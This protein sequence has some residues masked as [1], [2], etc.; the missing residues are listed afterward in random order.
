MQTMTMLDALTECLKTI[1]A[2]G[3]AGMR[4]P[5]QSESFG[6]SLFVAFVRGWG[7]EA[8]VEI[9]PG[10]SGAEVTVGWPSTTFSPAAA[11][12]AAVLHG[13]VADLACLL[14]ATLAR[15]TIEV[16]P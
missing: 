2:A 10:K 3:I 5:Q 9:R 7:I 16:T 14:E 6:G 11:R 4:A 13:Q 15:M 8:H 12:A 1:Q